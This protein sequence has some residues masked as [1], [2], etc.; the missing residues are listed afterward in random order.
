MINFGSGK[1]IAVPTNLADGTAI[2]NPTPVILGSMQDVSLDLS[3]DIKTLYGSKR[4]PIAVGQ[5]KGK[6]EIKAKYAEIDGGVMGSLF[7]GK[8]STA[9]IKAAV[10]DF[11]ATIPATP[12]QV[13]IAPPSTGTFVADLGVIFS[14]TGVQL[15]RVASAPT[16]GQYSVNVATGVYTFAAADTGLGIKISYEYSA[17]AGGQIWT[18]TNDTMGYTP[19]FTLLLQNGYDG[20]NMV[21]KLNRCV[22]GKLSV[23]L[24]SDDFAVYD[25]EAEA[26]SDA[27]GSLGYICLF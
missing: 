19:S 5:G 22:S 23:P 18:M 26:F 10:F 11:A 1:L 27:A 8:A 7:F 12:F 15:T 25:F 17:A 21:C 16:T 9:G 6:T 3:V 20:K 14:V 4:Y 2:A 24:K 13:T